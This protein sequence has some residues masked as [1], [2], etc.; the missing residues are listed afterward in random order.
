M[1]AS[2]T[3]SVSE[4]AEI[5]AKEGFPLSESERR[6]IVAANDANHD[7][8]VQF[9]STLHQTKSLHKMTNEIIESNKKLS[10]ASEKQAS[11]L[12]LATWA[13]VLAT[14]GLIVAP[15]IQKWLFGG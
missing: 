1:A 15:F 11:R 9:A 7:T 12:T 2:A 10:A 5:M 13:L 14:V 4:W 8:A 3:F 6:L